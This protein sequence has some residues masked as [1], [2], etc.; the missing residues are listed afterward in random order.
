MSV[1]FLAI[2]ISIISMK[3]DNKFAVRAIKVMHNYLQNDPATFKNFKP[4]KPLL[5]KMDL[6]AHVM[7]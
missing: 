7:S 5:M 4:N 3:E 1:S 6:G 2:L